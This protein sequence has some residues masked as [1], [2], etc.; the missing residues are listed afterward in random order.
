LHLSDSVLHHGTAGVAV[1][2]LKRGIL[3]LAVEG[4]FTYAT[5]VRGIGDR[6]TGA[7]SGHGQFLLPRSFFPM[8]FHLLSPALISREAPA[9][10]RRRAADLA[11]QVYLFQMGSGMV[12]C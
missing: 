11:Q 3:A 6:A 12:L 5:L 10:H 8:G 9:E 4:D 2:T 1:G 7:Q